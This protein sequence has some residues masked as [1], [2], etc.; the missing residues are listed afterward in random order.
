MTLLTVVVALLPKLLVKTLTVNVLLELDGTMNAP[1][2]FVPRP[3]FVSPGIVVPAL[4]EVG[5]VVEATPLPRGPGTPV[6]LDASE[7]ASPGVADTYTG[8]VPAD[9][10]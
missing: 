8:E 9:T 4:I 3:E 1:V 10:V 2:A 7:T 6:K 5:I